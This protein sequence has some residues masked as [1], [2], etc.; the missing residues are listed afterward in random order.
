MRRNKKI[1]C[2]KIEKKTFSIIVYE[3]LQF[4]CSLILQAFL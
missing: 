1:D 3:Q 4:E 2:L